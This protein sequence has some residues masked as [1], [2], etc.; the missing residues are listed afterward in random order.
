MTDDTPTERFSAADEPTRILPTSAAPGAGAAGRS[1]VDSEKPQSRALLFTLIGIGIALL[2]AI[3]VLALVLFNRDD[4]P[5]PAP[6][7]SETASGTPTATA[8]APSAS[9][10]DAPAPTET[11]APPVSTGPTFDSFSAPASAGCTGE[12]SNVDLTFSWSSG[13]AESA[14]ISIGDSDEA[15]A[16]GLPPVYTLTELQY[17][18]DFPSQTYTVTLEG[19][20]GKVASNTVTVTQ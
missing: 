3:V 19:A 13:N 9:A 6:I 20:D 8:P 17:Q 1:Q 11:S 2:I 12:V 5:A 7:V 16:S 10:S 14:S 4:T 15:F 18:C